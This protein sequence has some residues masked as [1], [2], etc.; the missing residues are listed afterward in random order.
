M[1]RDA[2]PDSINQPLAVLSHAVVQILVGIAS[3][4][5]AYAGSDDMGWTQPMRV[6]CA[7][8]VAIGVAGLLRFFFKPRPA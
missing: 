4:L 2:M 8:L 5:G 1:R 3:G 7:A 6:I